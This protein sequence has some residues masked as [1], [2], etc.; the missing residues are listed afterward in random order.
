VTDYLTVEEIVAI[1][2]EIIKETG[3]HAGIISKG[4]L[5]FVIDQMQI[6][7]DIVGKA[8]TLFFGI[9]TSHPFVDGNKRTAISSAE[10]FLKE[11]GYELTA[12]DEELWDIVHKISEGKLKFRKVVF[13]IK[14]RIK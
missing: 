11:N 4:N 13:W 8:S 10:T 1:H 5:D 3:G 7:K 2:D 9:I 6:P 12:N 14:D